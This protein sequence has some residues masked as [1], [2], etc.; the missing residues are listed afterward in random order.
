MDRVNLYQHFVSHPHTYTS[1]K[2]LCNTWTL[3]LTFYLQRCH[4]FINEPNI[5]YCP[6]SAYVIL[7]VIVVVVI[8]VGFVF[9]SVF[10]NKTNVLKYAYAIL[11][12][13]CHVFIY[14]TNINYFPQSAYVILVV[15]VIMVV[16]VFVFV[17]NNKTNVSKYAYVILEQLLML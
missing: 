13:K 2:C 11:E 1:R 9:V 17:F 5:N 15:I 3:P 14:K 8:L 4:V 7:V 12:Q 6:Q 10:N 16:F